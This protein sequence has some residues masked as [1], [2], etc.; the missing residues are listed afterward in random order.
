[1]AP[2]PTSDGEDTARAVM[3]RL[4]VDLLEAKD[5]LT[6]AKISQAH[7]ANKD[8]AP[9][10]EFKIGDRVLLATAHCRRDYMQKK[11]G[12]V[13]KFMP[14]FDGPFEVTT[15]FPESSTYTLHLP[16]SSKIHRTFHSSLLRPCIENDNELFPSRTLERPGPIVTEDGEAEYYID[17]I[18]DERTRG[19]GKQFLVCWLGYGAESD[20]WL[21]RHELA[22]TDAYAKW[23]E[24]RK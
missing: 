1:M 12:R 11:D 23:I 14:R 16:D 19:R 9:D 18:I 2:E 20:L 5:S 8:R 21:P 22:D 4:T 15:A 6:A 10:H 3:E 7:H 13:A 17:Q 24:K